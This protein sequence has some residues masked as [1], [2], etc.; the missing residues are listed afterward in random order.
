[1][2]DILLFVAIHVV[3]YSDTFFVWLV[4]D[5]YAR[6]VIY[7]GTILLGFILVSVSL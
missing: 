6:V 2:C 5:M 7:V 1:M 4:V 3:A